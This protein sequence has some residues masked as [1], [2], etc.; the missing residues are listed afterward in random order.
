MNQGLAALAGGWGLIA[1]AAAERLTTHRG[2]AP[3]NR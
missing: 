1:W 3:P 2:H